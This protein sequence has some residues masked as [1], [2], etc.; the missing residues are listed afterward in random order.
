MSCERRTA[1]FFFQFFTLCFISNVYK[2]RF[3]DFRAE[4]KKVK[5]QAEPSRA[6][7]PSARAMARAS[8]ART[9]HYLL[10]YVVKDLPMAV[11]VMSKRQMKTSRTVAVAWLISIYDNNV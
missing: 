1:I 10:V 7:H 8:S 11:L 3:S 2:Q 9:H 5:S 4:W 6:Q